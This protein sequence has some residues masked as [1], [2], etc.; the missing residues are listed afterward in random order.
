L[1]RQ[2]GRYYREE[3]ITRKLRADKY[4]TSEELKRDLACIK[5]VM[6]E[7]GSCIVGYRWSPSLNIFKV[8][9]KTFNSIP[10]E[11]TKESQPQTLL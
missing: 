4:L 2:N 1:A 3:T 9:S 8:E 5:A 6:K 10:K 11:E 7:D